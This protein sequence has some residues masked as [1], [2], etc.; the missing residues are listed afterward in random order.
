MADKPETITWI[1]GA[2]RSGTHLINSLVCTGEGCGPFVPE[3]HSVDSAIAAWKSVQRA[4]VTQRYFFESQEGIDAF[5]RGHIRA[6]VDSAWRSLDMPRHLIL[7][8][9]M[10]TPLI[11]ELLIHFPEWRYVVVIRDPKDVIASEIR[12]WKKDHSRETFDPG[13][14]EKLTNQY[15]GY[16]KSLIQ[17]GILQDPRVIGVEYENIVAQKFGDL[18]KFLGYAIHA[19]KVWSSDR[20]DIGV[21]YQGIRGCS[22]QWGQEMTGSRVASFGELLSPFDAEQ[23]T[24]S[25]RAI[26][27]QFRKLAQ[28]ANSKRQAA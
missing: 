26:T 3:F 20:F 19:D 25:T 17:D 28:E 16:Y 8:H 18:E 14:I 11:P 5:Y 9:C 27:S 4:F 21:E 7:K 24:Q 6:L 15:L 10:L 1:V 23:I 12:V 13:L 22:E 2:P